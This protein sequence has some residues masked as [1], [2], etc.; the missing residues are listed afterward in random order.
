MRVVLSC[1]A[2][3]AL[4]WGTA[5]A[6]ESRYDV[7]LRGGTVMDGT[8]K[9]ARRADVAL[10]GDRIAAI[11]AIDGTAALHEDT[12]RE[13]MRQPYV[14]VGSDA[15]ALSL[16]RA[17]SLMPLL[18]RRAPGSRCAVLDSRQHTDN[19]TAENTS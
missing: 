3:L 7:I 4:Q 10:R 18:H 6:Q 9:P 16:E 19:E 15:V 17:E 1:L 5:T 14:A 11:G 8:G 13:V 2:A 12:L